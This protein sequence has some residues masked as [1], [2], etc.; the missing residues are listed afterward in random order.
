MRGLS[1][2]SPTDRRL[3]V[4]RRAATPTPGVTRALLVIDNRPLQKA[5]WAEFHAAKKRLEKVSRDLHRH[6]Q[7]D[8]P[9]Y[10]KWVSQTFPTFITALREL[11][12]EVSTKARQVQMAQ[13]MSAVTGRSLRKVWQEQ[14][15]YEADPAAFEK[16]YG[17]D[18]DAHT[19]E[20]S[21]AKS[22][23]ARDPFFDDEPDPFSHGGRDPFEGM[24]RA[25]RS[26]ASSRE[27]KEIYRR[28]VQRLHP[29][30]GG[31]WTPSRKRLWHEVQ[32]AWAA[33]DADWLMR[34]EVEW[35]TANEV[36]TQSSPLSRLRQ[37]ITELAGARRD[38]EYK[39]SDYR[40]SV[41]WRFTLSPKKRDAL[42]R[43]TET[44]FRHDI[45][46]LKNQLAYLNATIAA[47][48]TPRPRHRDRE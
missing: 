11:H 47:W 2:E 21:S 8:A 43:R 10:E 13:A 23:G 22:A 36:L 38:A 19:E 44:S 32:Q 20:H 41:Q 24:A 35:E 33:G 37:A 3:R 31:E 15:E 6:E 42:R 29:D 16:K 48:E 5:A 26:E 34:L 14:K 46:F 40:K 17:D 28:L 39:L 12:Q 18:Q 7:V 25:R 45:D 4:I 1:F 30:R 9:A 27:A